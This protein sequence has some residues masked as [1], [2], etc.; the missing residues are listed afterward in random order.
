MA[1]GDGQPAL[2]AAAAAIVHAERHLGIVHAGFVARAVSASASVAAL[3]G[4]APPDGQEIV[5]RKRQAKADKEA[6]RRR[7]D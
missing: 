1:P 5:A 3:A 2:A 7:R 4:C 6:K